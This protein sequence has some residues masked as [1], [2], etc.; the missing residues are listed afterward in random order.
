VRQEEV[1]TGDLKVDFEHRRVTLKGEAVKLTPTEYSLL[2][3]LVTHPDKVLTHRELLST[4]WG[5]EYRDETEYLRVYLGRLR[6]KL[7]DDPAQPRYLLTE[8][9]VGYRFNPNP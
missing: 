1:S 6:R 7:E 5:A 3:Q 9:G 4:V 2:E 8:A